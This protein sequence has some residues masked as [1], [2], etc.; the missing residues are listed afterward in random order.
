MAHDLIHR[1]DWTPAVSAADTIIGRYSDPSGFY[2]TPAA[3]AVP[4]NIDPALASD[5]NR[6]GGVGLRLGMAQNF[7][8]SAIQNLE[9]DTATEL[10]S[11]FDGLPQSVQ[12]VVFGEIALGSWSTARATSQA[13]IDRFAA[14]GEGQELVRSWRGRAPQKLGIVLKRISNIRAKLS[15]DEDATLWDW[16]EDLDGAARVAV[17]K[18][19][20][21]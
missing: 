6:D 5:W 8:R 14:D 15:A 12:S 4:A 7:V 9:E 18:E 1:P 13:Q 10:L 2:D 17:L 3:V 11:G 16:F 21:R 20:G 19:L